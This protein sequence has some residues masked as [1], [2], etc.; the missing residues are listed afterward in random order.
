M[1]LLTKETFRSFYA[2]FLALLAAILLLM[3]Y[4]SLFIH[5]I[6]FI[7]VLDSLGKLSK[8]N[9]EVVEELGIDFKEYTEAL[10][11]NYENNLH[12]GWNESILNRVTN[13][14]RVRKENEN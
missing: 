9:R 1:S 10:E 5:S 13:S 12:V 7:Y 4:L 8:V 11:K 2:I 6:S 3:I 14:Y